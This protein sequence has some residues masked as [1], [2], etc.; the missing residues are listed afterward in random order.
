MIFF[1]LLVN[2]Y[3]DLFFGKHTPAV[4]TIVAQLNSIFDVTNVQSKNI[5]NTFLILSYVTP[6]MF[7]TLEEL[8][9]P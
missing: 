4:M 2:F 8:F 5:K 1:Q 7:C 9:Y 6:L 3:L